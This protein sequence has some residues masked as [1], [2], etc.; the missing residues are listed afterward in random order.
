MLANHRHH[1]SLPPPSRTAPNAGVPTASA[2]RHP[3][4]HR[5]TTTRIR[6][7]VRGPTMCSAGMTPPRDHLYQRQTR[8]TTG[9]ISLTVSTR[10]KQ[11]SSVGGVRTGERRHSHSRSSSSMQGHASSASVTLARHRLE[12][13]L[14]LA[15][16]EMRWATSFFGSSV[17][18]GIINSQGNPSQVLACR[19][20]TSSATRSHAVSVS[21]TMG[22]PRSRRTAAFAR[23]LE[24]SQHQSRLHCQH[25]LLRQR[26]R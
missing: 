16:E 11:A 14:A 7:R 17:R 1:I 21:T 12:T 8:T 26:V 23:Q 2:I 3:P 4:P 9:I 19:S 13:S 18:R 10:G 24:T 25:R 22:A 15:H 6:T 5:M 20:R